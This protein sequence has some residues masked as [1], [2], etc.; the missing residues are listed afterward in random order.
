MKQLNKLNFEI[1]K[2][3]QEIQQA[4]TECSA[5]QQHVA[6]FAVETA[7]IFFIQ[8]YDL[9]AYISVQ[10]LAISTEV[11]LPPAKLAFLQDLPQSFLHHF[12][13]KKAANIIF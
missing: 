8:P 12:P 5:V 1:Q 11:V 9:T 10:V 6:E 2:S 3:H 13:H 7:W 4:L